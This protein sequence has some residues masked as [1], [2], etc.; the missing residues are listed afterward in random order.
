[1]PPLPQPGQPP[2]QPFGLGALNEQHL[3]GT[4]IQPAGYA[5]LEITPHRLLRI[6]PG[7]RLDYFSV[8]GNW[9]V[10]PRF[11]ARVDLHHDF[12]RTTIKGGAGLYSQ[13]PQFQEALAPAGNPHL[14]SNRA[15]QY[16]VGAEQEFT[17]YL[18]ASVEGF[19]KRLDSQVVSSASATGAANANYTNLGT[20]S[21]IGSELL[22]KYKP[23]ARFFG[24]IAYTLSR[25]VRTDGPGLA[26]HLFQY[27]QTHILTVLGSYRLGHG[28]EIG[29]RF[30]LVTGDP[31]TPNVCDPTTAGCNPNR[32]NGLFNAASGTYTAIP[33]VAPYSE[34]LPMFHQLDIRVDK[35]YKFKRWQLSTYLDVQNVY[36]QANVEGLQYNYTT[37]SGTT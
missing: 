28:W 11:N 8:T 25:S 34:R 24:W 36:N 4:G 29:A 27:D 33:S 15:Y 19:Y 21:V 17:Q 22:V 20:G 35:T 26:E 10:N 37:R 18:E 23:D 13:P 2:N 1:M 6:V 3:R 16:S 32:T 12:P 9:D 30:R 14:A 5:E 31:V 7:L